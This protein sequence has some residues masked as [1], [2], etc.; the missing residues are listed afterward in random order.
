MANIVYIATSLDGYIA[1]EDDSIDWLMELPNPTQSDY[2]F[3]LFMERIDA[4]IMGRRTFE[5]VMGFGQWPY[6]ATKPLFVL[7]NTLRAI[8]T[9]LPAPVELVN[10]DLKSILSS[11]NKKG[12]HEFYVDGGKTI[13]SFLREDLID[14]I[15]ITRI[16]ILLGAG[17]PLFDGN[18]Q[19][20]KFDHVETELHHNMLVKSRYLRKR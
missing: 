6:P 15:I 13:R 3:S 1:R 11:L 2:G 18:N 9:D 5:T 16:P 8:P 17:I 10:G 19:E 12:L 4:I 14:E 20:L 7:S